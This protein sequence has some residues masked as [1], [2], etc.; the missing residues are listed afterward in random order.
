[1]SEI[2]RKRE[3]ERV[4]REISRDEN[5]L[6]QGSDQKKNLISMQKREGEEL[7]EERNFSGP[8]WRTR[9]KSVQ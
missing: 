1:M 3:R 5:Y 7:G 2:E 8:T 6:L 9:T 4:N